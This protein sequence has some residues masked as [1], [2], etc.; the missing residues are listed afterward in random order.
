M[1]QN[2]TNEIVNHLMKWLLNFCHPDFLLTK[3][4]KF[5]NDDFTFTENPVWALKIPYLS[6]EIQIIIGDC[7]QANEKDMAAL[8]VLK[9]SPLYAIFQEN[10]KESEENMIATSL[11][12]K[13][14][15]S[16]SHL[17]QGSFLA[18]MEQIREF[19]S[20]P[21]K[22]NSDIQENFTSLIN[23]IDF[24]EAMVERQDDF[25]NKDFE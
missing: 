1:N 9:G 15:I 14:W 18:A 19:P 5:S 3:T 24:R 10:S 20:F 8:I 2:L 4:L 12:G 17:L 6:Q 13:S 25:N 23:F 22:I 21:N 11:D 16:C 7:S